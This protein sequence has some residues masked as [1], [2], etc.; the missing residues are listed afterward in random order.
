MIWAILLIGF[1]LRI[2]NLNQSLWLDEGIN[3]L[4]VQ[5]YSFFDLITQ[6]AK[7]DFHPPGWFIILWV[8]GKFF[9][10][11]EVAVRMPSVIFG[12]LTI[13]V[14]YLIGKNIAKNSAK[15]FGLLLALLLALNPLHIYYS[16]EAR[17]YALA[18][19]AVAINLFLFIKMIKEEKVN[20]IYLILSN[21]LVL[22][23]D[24]LAYFIYPAQIIYLL[25]ST[26]K[27]LIKKWMISILAAIVVGLWWLPVF[28][29]QLD[30][31]S[32]A[33]ANLPTWKFVVGGFDFKTL[34]LTLIKFIIGRITIADKI[35]YI[36]LLIPICSVFIFLA[37]RGTR[38][39]IVEY[40]KLILALLIVPLTIATLISTVIP[41]FSYFRVLYL[42]PLFFALIAGGIL[43]FKNSVKVILLSFVLIIEI[44]CAIVYLTNP[45]FQREDWRGL[46]SYLGKEER[47]LVLFE[48]SGT[49]PPFDYYAGKDLNARGALKDF[50]AKD[51][52]TVAGLDSLTQGYDQIFL[53]D[54]LV[55]ISDQNRLV[56]KKLIDLNFKHKS[57]KDFI[58]V[59]FV[60]E[61]VKE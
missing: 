50:P 44:F 33:S 32:V 16:Q 58:G 40:R 5:N 10:Y 1:I 12:V 21:V 43:S 23:S 4:A 24:Y 11:S 34:P 8:W 22:A 41:I 27:N 38:Y 53:V 39:L 36:S 17:M 48:S 46:V 49:L 45:L 6:Y 55:Q 9:G 20:I 7:A 29:S 15:E 2:F 19:L 14:A 59:G 31:G 60:Y 61:Y 51:E 56:A 54:Y 30:V 28:I 57:T 13:Y 25:I 47:S 37:F 26:H 18:T 42:V 52:S 35:L 3:V